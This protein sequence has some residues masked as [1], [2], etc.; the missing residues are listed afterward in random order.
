MK[1][2]E[3]ISGC[4][5][6]GGAPIRC[7]AVLLTA[8]L[9]AAFP[10][11]SVQ[12]GETD[13]AS[14]EILSAAAAEAP[15]GGK[16]QAA[17]WYDKYVDYVT[18]RGWMGDTEDGTFGPE[19]P[20][21][22]AMFVTALYNMVQLEIPENA[23]ISGGKA[24]ADGEGV[25][26][27]GEN[28]EAAVAEEM[29]GDV[30]GDEWFVPA[31]EWAAGRGI[32]SGIDG[33]FCPGRTIDREMMAVMIRRAAPYLEISSEG[34]WSISIDYTDLE[35][36]SEWAVDGI[37]F[38]AVF[39]IMAGDPDGSFAPKRDITRAESAAVLQRIGVLR[40]GKIDA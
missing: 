32:V 1:T 16:E 3:K 13:G 14:A 11:L 26:E 22:R 29:F 25:G 27:T 9:L 35:E 6:A 23:G 17:E 20:M 33:N 12:A 39:D 38:C 34:D 31:L 28:G 8:V 15:A 30:T 21:T 4:G 7:M 36:I 19:E 40:D 5:R 37:A 24:E 10:F 18:S 2:R